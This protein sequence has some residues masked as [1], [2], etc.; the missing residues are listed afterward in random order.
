MRGAVCTRC[1]RGPRFV[2][3]V[4]IAYTKLITNDNNTSMYNIHM[5]VTYHHRIKDMQKIC[6]GLK[7]NANDHRD[8]R[9][10][11]SQITLCFTIKIRLIMILSITNEHTGF[12]IITKPKNLIR[13]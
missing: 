6:K 4:K 9:S 10:L 1:G 3:T 11:Q 5:F 2:Y 8:Q 7:T 13:S 12:R